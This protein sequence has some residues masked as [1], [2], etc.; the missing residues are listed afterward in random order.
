ML[1]CF[2]MGLS[3]HPGFVSGSILL[4]LRQQ[5]HRRIM[6]R[7]R[8]VARTKARTPVPKRPGSASSSVLKPAGNGEWRGGGY[9]W[10]DVDALQLVKKLV[11]EYGSMFQTLLSY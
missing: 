6:M 7:A 9:H 1:K 8:M 2:K 5:Q 10:M 11:V 3:P 4:L